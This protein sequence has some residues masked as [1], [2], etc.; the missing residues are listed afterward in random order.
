ML[1]FWGIEGYEIR[2]FIWEG[3]YVEYEDGQKVVDKRIVRRFVNKD[4]VGFLAWKGE[5]AVF[6]VVF[7]HLLHVV[8]HY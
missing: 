2:M 5:C 3:V 1:G 7:T 4:E 6:L 8:L